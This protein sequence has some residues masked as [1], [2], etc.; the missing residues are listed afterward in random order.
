MPQLAVSTSRFE[1]SSS[2]ILPRSLLA[3]FS[4]SVPMMLRSVVRARLT[5]WI[6][7][8]GDVVL[9]RLDALL[10]VLDLEVD[11]R[12]DFGVEVVVGDDLLRLR[13][14]QHL[15]NVDLVEP[16]DA[17]QHGVQAG[18]AVVVVL[19]QALHEAAMRGAHDADAEQSQ[20]DQRHDDADGDENGI[21]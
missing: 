5:T 6:L 14:D 7:I 4:D 21:H 11:L 16:V 18:A 2:L 13:F 17:R 19:A 15:A 10:V 20:D 1:R 9:R 8:V 12:V 3:D